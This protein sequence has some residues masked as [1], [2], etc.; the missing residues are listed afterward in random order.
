[1]LGALLLPRVQPR[2]GPD[3]TVAADSLLTALVL[4]AFSLIADPYAAAAAA[5]LLAGVSW[6]FVLSSLQVAAQLALPNWV[7]A[8]GL[9]LGGS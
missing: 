6:I 9:S 2:L 5:S 7:R 8:R 3:G 4:A 1:V